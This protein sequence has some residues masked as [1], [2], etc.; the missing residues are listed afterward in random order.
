MPI[1]SNL[2]YESLKISK[3]WFIKDNTYI[4]VE[5]NKSYTLIKQFIKP[6]IF[7]VFKAT[8]IEI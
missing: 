8:G 4:A 1:F 2:Q 3:N 7:D 6:M 5:W